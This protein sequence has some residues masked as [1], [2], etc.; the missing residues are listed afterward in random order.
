[1]R[2]GKVD[3][4]K[5][6]VPSLIILLLFA[7]AGLA[8]ESLTFENVTDHL[9]LRKRTSLHAK[10]YWGEVQGQ[11][12][13]WSAKVYDVSGGRG[14]AKVLAAND[15]RRKYKG[16]N[17]VLVTYDME[18]AADLMVDSKITFKGDLYKYKARKGNP[19]IIY[20]NNVEFIK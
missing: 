3:V 11:T 8:A 12:V 10:T 13:T 17:L 9:D 14:K 6:V 7:T 1:M 18:A 19:V 4:L 2:M 15:S 16:Y 5:A 20:L